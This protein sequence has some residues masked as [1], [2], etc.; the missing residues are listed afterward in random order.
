MVVGADSIDDMAR[1]R[2]GGMK[3]LFTQIYAPNAVVVPAQVHVRACPP[4]RR[5]PVP[6][7]ADRAVLAAGQPEQPHES[8][9]YAVIDVDDCQAV[10]SWR[11]CRSR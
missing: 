2:H 6:G 5:F 1:L 8:T 3:K 9:K 10:L 4:T 11:R 7:R